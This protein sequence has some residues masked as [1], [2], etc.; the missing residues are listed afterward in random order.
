MK[1]LKLKTIIRRA[2]AAMAACL[3]LATVAFAEDVADSV[4]VT[5]TTRLLTDIGTALTILCPIVGG[6]MA[7]SFAIRRSM[8]DETDGKMWEKRIKTAIICGVGGGLMMGII[9][10]ISSYYK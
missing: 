9:T 5:G 2:A 10:L 4:L 7:V 1:N 8:A 6:V 3:A